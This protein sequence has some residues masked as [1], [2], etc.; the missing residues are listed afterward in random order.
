MRHAAAT[1][2]KLSLIFVA[3]LLLI[4]INV[5]LAKKILTEVTVRKSV[6]VI[7]LGDLAH[8]PR[9]NYHT[10][11]L[12]KAGFQV[13]FIGYSESSL[14]PSITSNPNIT[15]IP[16]QKLPE[17]VPPPPYHH[18]HPQ[19]SVPVLLPLVLPALLL[20]PLTRP[21]AEPSRHPRSPLRLG[22]LPRPPLQARGGLPQ[23]HVLHPGPRP[24]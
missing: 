23:L 5:L 14:L 21:P 12:A 22:L 4:V 20:L 1:R 8:S 3:I 24:Q 17:W 11:S 13:N 18:L 19:G 15:V 10:L 9:M 16:L 7:V 6:C 2:S